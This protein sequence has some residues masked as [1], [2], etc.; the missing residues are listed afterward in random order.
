MT[1]RPLGA[2][3]AAAAGT[4]YAARHETAAPTVDL[5]ADIPA[6]RTEEAEQER[7]MS[8]RL[9]RDEACAWTPGR[10]LRQRMPLMQPRAP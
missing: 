1:V 2:L 10:P 9:A 8:V 6:P 7:S 3:D 4:A 5:P